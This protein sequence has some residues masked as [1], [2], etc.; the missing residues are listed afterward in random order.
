M[1]KKSNGKLDKSEPYIKR[2][3]CPDM[4]GFQYVE[5]CEKN[6]K[7]KDKCTAYKNYIEPG[8]FS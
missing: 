6:C 1:S 3:W 8:L 4:E 7:K 2:I 5:A